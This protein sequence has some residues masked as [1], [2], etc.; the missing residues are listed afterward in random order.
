MIKVFVC[1]IDSISGEKRESFLKDFP[2]GEN[3]KNRLLKIKNP[4]Y[5]KSSLAA[6][7][8]LASLVE[9]SLPLI[10]ERNENGKPFFKDMPQNKFNL[11]HSG[12]I[13]VAAVS[14][15]DIGVDIEFIRDGMDTEKI[16]KRFFG[17]SD[18]SKENFFKL[19]TQEEA[20]S[21][22]LGV[23]LTASLSEELPDDIFKQFEIT[24][25]ASRGYI[26]IC[27]EGLK[28]MGESVE[29]FTQKDIFIKQ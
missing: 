8:S 19:W 17:I 1:D 11:S 12:G 18:I 3:E 9:S 22:M 26:C 27:S 14:D 15:N 28:D 6:L 5:A 25:K 29:I 2:F 10:I 13:A 7:I 20:Y 23:P 16:S 4:E 24:F 21:K